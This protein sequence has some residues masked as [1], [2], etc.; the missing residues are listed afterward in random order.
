MIHFFSVVFL[1]MT[2]F[3]PIHDF[4][5]LHLS[6]ILEDWPIYML[7]ERVALSDIFVFFLIILLYLATVYTLS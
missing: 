5:I 3:L 4:S 2:Q 6:Y 1:P 7:F